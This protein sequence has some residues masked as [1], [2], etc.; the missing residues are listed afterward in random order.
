MLRGA[1]RGAHGGAADVEP[2]A[3]AGD[4]HVGQSPLLLQLAGVTQRAQVREDAVLE[5]GQEDDRELQPLGGVQ[6]HQRDDPVALVAVGDL[7]GVGHQ[8]HPLEERLQRPRVD[9]L[10]RVGGGLG[11]LGDIGR[12]GDELAG[13]RDQLGEVLDPGLVLRVVGAL[14]SGEVAAA[15]QHRLQHHVGRLPHVDQQPQVVD[16][17]HERLDRRHRPG[18]D[19]R[20]LLD[21]AQRL[22]VTDPVALGQRRHAGLGPLADAA[23]GGVEDAPQRDRVARVDQRAQVGERVL[24]LAPLVEADAADDLVGQADPDEHLLEHPA[25]GV[26]AVEHR[27]VARLGQLPRRAAGRSRRRRT[28][29]RRAR[30]RRRSRPAGRRHRR[31]STA[32]WPAGACCGR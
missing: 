6:G 24:D 26:G 19:A 12:V 23:L 5:P 30:R 18:G 9:R 15:G 27:D 25:L 8:R 2:F 28:A 22:E 14:E 3:G 10:V 21:A 32:A 4:A 11:R 7:V 20:R 17:L 31:R 13:H 16:H 29:P 1:P